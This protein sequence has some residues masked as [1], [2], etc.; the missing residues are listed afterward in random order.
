[1]HSKFLTRNTH[2]V[3][4]TALAISFLV[5][6]VAA[7]AAAE[8]TP[9]T[10]VAPNYQTQGGQVNFEITLECG[11]TNSTADPLPL[12]TEILVGLTVYDASG[13]KQSLLSGENL[14]VNRDLK[15][16]PE[17]VAALKNTVQSNSIQ[18][19]GAPK[20]IV[21]T[22]GDTPSFDFPAQTV[23]IKQKNEKIVIQ[24]HADQKAMGD[25]KRYFL[26]AAWPASAR[27]SCDKKD[28]YAR[29]G[30]RRDGYVIGDDYG[31]Y[32]LTVYPGLEVNHVRDDAKDEEWSAERWI[33]ERLR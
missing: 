33:V 5:S 16:N 24:F 8:M 28:E 7:A 1:M 15:A 23:K 13:V 26:L 6:A 25:D 10:F 4:H 3:A 29:S 32:P 31:V 18:V 2:K 22:D 19:A 9:C 17:I 21:L 12:A 11:S 27:K 30:C 20:W 14:S